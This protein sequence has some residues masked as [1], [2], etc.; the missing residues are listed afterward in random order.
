MN[1]KWMKFG[2]LIAALV[3]FVGTAKADQACSKERAKVE[4]KKEDV[5][6]ACG[7]MCASAEQKSRYTIKAYLT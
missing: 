4:Q 5:R 2:L 3:G 1:R 6:T 7:F